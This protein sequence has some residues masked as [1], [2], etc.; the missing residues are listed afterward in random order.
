[1]HEHTMPG[2]IPQCSARLTLMGSLSCCALSLQP[3]SLART[4]EVGPGRTL[5]TCHYDAHP[6]LP[7]QGEK[8]TERERE[9]GHLP[10]NEECAQQLCLSLTECRS[11]APVL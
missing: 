7:E 9:G 1:M 5:V 4:E 8:E 10:T 2:N 3:D 11:S 6:T